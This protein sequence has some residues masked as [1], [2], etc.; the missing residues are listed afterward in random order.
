MPDLNNVLLMG[1]LT[2]D[3]ELRYIPSGDAVC[4]LGLA[5]NRKYRT[6]SGDDKEETCFV[7]VVVW[8]KPAEACGKYLQKGSP[9]FVE[10]RLKYDEW[11]KDGQKRSRLLVVAN[12]VQFM[13]NPN[14]GS[15]GSDSRRNESVGAS[16]PA[17]V[18]P[19]APVV[20]SVP[21]VTNSVPSAVNNVGDD[22]VPF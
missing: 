12:R 19:V 18:A 22:N 8:R 16:G 20:D 10:G 14:G 5:V 15:G 21:P 2:R 3:P 9:V 6:G 17:S 11:E 13:S 1:N 4:D 7:N